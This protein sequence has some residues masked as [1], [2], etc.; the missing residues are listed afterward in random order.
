[1][2]RFSL[3][4]CVC[5]IV[6]FAYGCT[7]VDKISAEDIGSITITGLETGGS[8]TCS[9]EQIAAFAEAYNSAVLFTNEVGTTHP[10]R[11]DVIYKDGT[12][13]VV[14]GGTQGFC[15]MSSEST[16]QQNIKSFKLDNWFEDAD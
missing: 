11:A 13:L 16:G 7:Y 9:E 15:T 12:A 2:R 8:L 10:Y 5:L 1:M 6:F 3:L 4:V 14:W